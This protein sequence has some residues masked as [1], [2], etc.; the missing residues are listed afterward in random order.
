MLTTLLNTLLTLIK[1]NQTTIKPNYQPTRINYKASNSKDVTVDAIN[2]SNLVCN[3]CNSKVSKLHAINQAKSAIDSTNKVLCD[4]CF[5]C[6]MIALVPNHKIADYY[7]ARYS[8]NMP[9]KNP[10]KKA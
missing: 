2:P 10:L 7:Q 1:G 6:T 5:A 8:F 9:L 4:H 3:S